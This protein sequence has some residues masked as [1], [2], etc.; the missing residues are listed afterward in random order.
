MTAAELVATWP[1]VPAELCQRLAW[2][3]DSPTAPDPGHS[4]PPR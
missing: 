3:L 2:L 4:D 1:P